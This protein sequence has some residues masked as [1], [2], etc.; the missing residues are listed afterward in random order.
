MKFQ[1]T[2][3]NLAKFHFYS[4]NLMSAFDFFGRYTFFSFYTSNIYAF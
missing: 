1:G 2:H 4:S 3:G